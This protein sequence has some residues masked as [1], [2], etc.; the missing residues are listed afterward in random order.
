[1]Q[2]PQNLSILIFSC[3]VLVYLKKGDF[4]GAK[5]VHTNAFKIISGYDNTDAS[6]VI[7]GRV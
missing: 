1:M 4:D 6:A 3:L 2:E 7:E 5:S